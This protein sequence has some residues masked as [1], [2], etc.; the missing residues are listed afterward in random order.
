MGMDDAYYLAIRIKELPI[1]YVLCQRGKCFECGEEVW[2][3]ENARRIWESIPILCMTCIE[4]YIKE[5]PSE[6]IDLM[7]TPEV[8]K[9]LK[10]Y[11]KRRKEWMKR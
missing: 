9:S 11:F 4:V 7:I 2:L 5:K 10:E 3:D 6:E 8:Q 1:P